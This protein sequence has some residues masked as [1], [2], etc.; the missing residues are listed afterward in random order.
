MFSVWLQLASTENSVALVLMWGKSNGPCGIVSQCRTCQKCF[1]HLDQAFRGAMKFGRQKGASD[2][3]APNLDHSASKNKGK[4][5][6]QS[7][8]HSTFQHLPQIWFSPV[9]LSPDSKP[10]RANKSGHKS[11]PG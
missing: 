4:V 3:N 2:K 11:S 6:K 1:D 9:G 7:F 5:P 8:A 10:D